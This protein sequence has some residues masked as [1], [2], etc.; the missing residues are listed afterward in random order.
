M[1]RSLEKFFKTESSG[2]I[3]MIASALL[4]LIA[5]NGSTAQWYFSFINMSVTIGLTAPLTYW[6]KDVL[7]VF[8]FLLVG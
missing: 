6:V 3:L 1:I 8:F 7:M 5:A 2:G 4:A